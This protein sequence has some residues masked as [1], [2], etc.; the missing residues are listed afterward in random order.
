MGRRSDRPRLDPHPPLTP[1]REARAALEHAA[2]TLGVSL[3]EAQRRAALSLV[4][5]VDPG[6][7]YV[8]PVD[9]RQG[10]LF[11]P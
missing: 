1:R 6:W 2:K 4:E 8:E 9:P 7:R 11:E 10:R 5:S 3:A